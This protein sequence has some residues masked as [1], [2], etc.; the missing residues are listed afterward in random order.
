M[1]GCASCGRTDRVLDR[2]TPAGRCCGWCATRT[3]LRRCARCGQDG[4]LVAR[5]AE[6]SICRSCY[7][8]D[9]EYLTE[10]ANC[11]KRRPRGFRRADGAILCI[12]CAPA[13]HHECSRCGRHRPASAHTDDGPVCHSCY[14]S[15][16][17]QCGICGEVRPIARRAVDEQPDTCF[18]CYRNIGECVVCGRTRPGNRVR[19]D[20]FHCTGCYPY[21]HRR[22]AECG[23]VKRTAAV[24]PLGEVCGTCYQRRVRKPASCSA[25]G[26]T[27][28]LVGR[29]AAGH[30]ICGPCS[31]SDISF[32]CRRCGHPG[33]IYTAGCCARCVL[34][35]RVRDLLS[36]DN[37]VLP[38]RLQPFADALLAV[39]HPRSV[40]NWL[41]RSASAKLLAALVTG[42]SEITHELLDRLPQDHSTRYVRGLLAASGVLP[43]RQEHLAQLTLWTANALRDLSPHHLGIIG[44][45]TE[46]CVLRDARRRAARDRYT[47]GAMIGD[48]TAIRTAID[49]LAWLD[50]H[51][52]ELAHIT[53]EHLDHWL[54][55]H[56]TKRTGIVPF[57]HWTGDRHLTTDLEL[58][59]RKYTLPQRFLDEDDHHQQL[60]RCLNDNT[61]PLEVRIVG[62]LIRLYGLP[63]AR[64][65]ALTT[66]KF[67]RDDNGAYLTLDRHPVLL[68]PKLARLIDQQ[69]ARPRRYSMFER[70]TDPT[71]R[72]LLPGKPP[73]RPRH[74]QGVYR[75][76][77]KLGLPTS[78]A[79]NTALIEAAAELPPIVL[80][81]LFGISPKTA[82]RWAQYAQ[83][84]WSDYLAAAQ[85][86]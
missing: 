23:K 35:D 41:R 53:Q 86:R 33:D 19:G 22:C 63:V 55:A 85:P 16:P 77:R 48:R 84:S 28:V 65:V 7:R 21:P 45:F 3:V 50:A 31:G 67:R 58:P 1:L 17:R 78:S 81:D 29:S 46:W 59:A 12:S 2:S 14:A 5:R 68:P 4:H 76:L 34:S 71:A 64:I 26:S 69:I 54:V 36:L 61:I 32:D 72:F 62:A 37:G 38:A 82:H 25:C 11:G 43:A 9:P 6:G 30:A 52:L 20:A 51:H 80:S 44:P 74:V 73:D 18:R 83:D 49:F 8:H 70:S 60:V 79:R 10:C 42:R 27:R 57:I 56:P 24:W 39:E 15:P 75:L 47:W 40:L 66:D 13:P